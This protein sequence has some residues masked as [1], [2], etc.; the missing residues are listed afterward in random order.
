[1][2][3]P[4]AV[5]DAAADGFIRNSHASPVQRKTAHSI[6]PVFPGPMSDTTIVWLPGPVKDPHSTVP[7]GSATSGSFNCRR[8]T[9]SRAAAFE[10]SAVAAVAPAE[11]KPAL[12]ETEP[13]ETAK[14]STQDA[15]QGST[16][17]LRPGS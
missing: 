9:T 4:A 5:I 11:E 10:Q 15:R 1:M 6:S 7:T 3:N 12:A 2:S 17:V 13:A 16:S 8:I 14:T